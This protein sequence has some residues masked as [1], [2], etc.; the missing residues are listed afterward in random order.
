MLQQSNL[1]TETATWKMTQT[2]K[3][4]YIVI[5]LSRYMFYLSKLLFFQKKTLKQ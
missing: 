5:V 4:I 3:N 2:F 1:S